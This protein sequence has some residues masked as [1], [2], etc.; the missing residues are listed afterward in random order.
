MSDK[1][2]PFKL[3]SGRMSR[4]VHVLPGK[5]NDDCIS[6]D[7]S[8]ICD[9]D[10][11]GDVQG[12]MT[13]TWQA[14]NIYSSNCLRSYECDCD[15]LNLINAADTPV[16]IK[17]NASLRAIVQCCFDDANQYAYEIIDIQSSPDIQT[18]VT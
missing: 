18:Q 2:V 17:A 11:L 8:S 6:G 9:S 14:R 12:Y 4:D 13:H 1:T 3:L 10:R 7:Q 5:A 15:D 16:S